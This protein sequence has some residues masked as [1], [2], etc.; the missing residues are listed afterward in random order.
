MPMPSNEVRRNL[1]PNEP[2]DSFWYALWVELWPSGGYYGY[3][4]YPGSHHIL[5][6]WG[7]GGGNER[8]ESKQGVFEQLLGRG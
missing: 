6:G 4:V 7:P 5:T 3:I 8:H 2:I 1:L